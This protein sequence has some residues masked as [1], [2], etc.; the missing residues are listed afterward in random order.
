MQREVDRFIEY[1]SAVKDASEHT[2]RGYASDIAQFLAFL[3]EAELSADPGSIDSRVLRRY[4]ARLH[5][6]GAARTSISRKLASL[7]ALFK[8]LLKKG[9][10][11]L[12]PTLGLS[13]P[14]LEKRLPK[15]LRPEQI[16][17]L[18]SR[19]D[20]SQPMG[21]RDAA[22]LE[23]LYATGVRVSELSGMDLSNLD[24]NAGEV[25][26]FGKG[27]KERIVL[28]GRAAREALATYLAQREARE[29]ERALFIN[30]F[31]G[32][33]SARSIHRLVDKYFMQVSDE[34]KI[35]PHVLRHTFATHMMEHGADLRSI[36]ELLGHVSI[37]TTQIYAHVSKERLK[38]V[39]E[40]AHPRAQEE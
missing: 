15:F 4:I 8:Y 17:S 1:I 28:I 3:D 12:D 19:P 20:I 31:G 30:R 36:Q 24:M 11:K 37:S 5:R 18:L 26:V 23:V 29:G 33:L 13:A 25:R 35:S 27:R 38:Q 22:I 32:R 10:I 2:V 34:M 16:E 14:K 21:A 39:Y 7:R 9:T 6:D 40:S